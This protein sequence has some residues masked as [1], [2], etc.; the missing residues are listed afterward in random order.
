MSVVTGHVCDIGEAAKA[1][2]PFERVSITTYP[3]AAGIDIGSASHF[4]AVPPDCDDEPV[5]EFKS[6]TEDLE[7]L[8]D[9]LVCCGV[10]TVAMESTGV[11]WIPLYEIL[12]ARGFDVN[13]VNA[14]HVKNV[15][16]RKSDVLDCQWLQQLMSYMAC[17]LV[18]FARQMKFACCVQ[19][20]DN[21]TCCWPLKV[22][23]FSICKKS[24]RNS[25]TN[26]LTSGVMFGC[27]PAD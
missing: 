25:S 1:A 10:D 2:I 9:W 4:V 19:Y 24:S 15:S 20:H 3:N 22:D 8:A 23:I 7:E 17:C 27:S 14:R 11:H 12:E 21:A 26:P 16:G 5:R 13:L 18:L 6:F